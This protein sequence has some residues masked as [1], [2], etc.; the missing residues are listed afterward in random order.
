MTI[1]TNSMISVLTIFSAVTW[2]LTLISGI[3][4][5]NILLPG[6]NKGYFFLVVMWIMFIISVAMLLFFRRKKR[7]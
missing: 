2:V 3:Y 1:K 4:G 7:I 5:M 6:Q